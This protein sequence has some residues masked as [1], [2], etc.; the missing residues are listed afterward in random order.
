[1]RPRAR[2][3]SCLLSQAGHIRNASKDPFRPTGNRPILPVKREIPKETTV[4]PIDQPLALRYHLLLK[5]PERDWCHRR[6]INNKA[7]EH[8]QLGYGTPPGGS[9]PRYTI[10]V[11]RG[12][13][14]GQCPFPQRRPLS[15]LQ[16]LQHGRTPEDKPGVRLP[17]LRE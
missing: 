13:T 8:F 6:G 5:E 14:A 11:Y 4:E 15:R 17:G 7:I 12:G 9:H 10:P 2:P 3:S 16:L 1:M